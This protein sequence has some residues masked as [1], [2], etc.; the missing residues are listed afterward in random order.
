MKTESG[1][2]DDDE[3]EDGE[4][5]EVEMKIQ[6]TKLE[7]GREKEEK[8]DK[9]PKKLNEALSGTETFE[10]KE[11]KNI[12]TVRKNIIVHTEKEKENLIEKENNIIMIDKNYKK[13]KEKEKENEKERDKEEDVNKNKN[14]NNNN[15]KFGLEIREIE[16][17]NTNKMTSVSPEKKVEKEVLQNKIIRHV[18]VEESKINKV[19]KIGKITSNETENIKAE[20]A[21]NENLNIELNNDNNNNNN[22]DNDDSIIV[23]RSDDIQDSNNVSAERTGSTSQ[24]SREDDNHR[25]VNDQKIGSEIDHKNGSVDENSNNDRS[26]KKRKHIDTELFILDKLNSNDNNRNHLNI[27]SNFKFTIITNII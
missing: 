1:S 14:N 6:I 26:Q 27:E 9:Y 4:E 25:Y 5:K 22:N 10:M 20:S 2:A 12:G 21:K 16:S 8:T 15:N 3:V 7:K 23:N 19:E 11:K 13:D 24:F 18:I 17:K